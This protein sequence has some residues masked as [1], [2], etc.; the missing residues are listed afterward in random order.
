MVVV[1]VVDFFLVCDL[2]G[3][4]NATEYIYVMHTAY[5]TSRGHTFEKRSMGKWVFVGWSGVY[6]EVRVFF[7]PTYRH[8]TQLT[9]T[10]TLSLMA[11][12]YC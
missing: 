7:P 5:Y 3:I 4:F 6:K 11:L 8:E 2:S 9:L 10:H 12:P 1:V